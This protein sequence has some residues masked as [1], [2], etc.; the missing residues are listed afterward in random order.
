LLFILLGSTLCAS[1]TVLT[2]PSEST[3]LAALCMAI[4]E[5]GAPAGLVHHAGR[6][7]QYHSC[8]RQQFL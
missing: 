2:T 3:L 7:S 4:G 5:R 8:P 1:Q 6:G